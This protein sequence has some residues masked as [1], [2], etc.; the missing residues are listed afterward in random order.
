MEALKSLVLSIKAL[1]SKVLGL[2]KSKSAVTVQDVKEAVQEKVQDTVQ[3]ATAKVQE[4][5]ESV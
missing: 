5:P 3:D 2:F 4:A 1:F